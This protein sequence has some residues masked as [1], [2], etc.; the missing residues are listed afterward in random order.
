MP[1]RNVRVGFVNVDLAHNVAVLQQSKART[2]TRTHIRQQNNRPC[3]PPTR[4]VHSCCSH[5]K[6]ALEAK[7]ARKSSK[8]R[9]W[10]RRTTE[11]HDWPH[12]HG[13]LGNADVRGRPA[14]INR[15]HKLREHR[16][17]MCGR[18][19][20]KN[21]HRVHGRSD[22]R[23]RP[24]NVRIHWPYGAAMGCGAHSGECECGLV[25]SGECGRSTS[26]DVDACTHFQWCESK[27][28]ARGWVA[29]LHLVSVRMPLRP[30]EQ[31]PRCV[32]P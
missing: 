6:R 23:C 26:S 7:L 15:T 18:A 16:Q 32:R 30:S 8:D 21:L 3:L 11:P 20:L 22:E 9:T 4:F 25:T 12:R 5:A 28:D 19:H 17:C 27:L 2:C 1:R 29:R 24:Q 10:P 31:P 13:T 14:V